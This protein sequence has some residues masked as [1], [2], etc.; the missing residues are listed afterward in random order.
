[1]IDACFFGGAPFSFRASRRG[2]SQW[3]SADT[4][5]ALSIHALI[6]V[7]TNSEIA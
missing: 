5:I 3:L 1:V 4:S 7:R 6:A 2:S